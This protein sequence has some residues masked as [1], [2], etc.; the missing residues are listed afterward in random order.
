MSEILD[1]LEYN[2]FCLVLVTVC[3]CGS[4]AGFYLG[5]VPEARYPE[6]LDC[7][8]LASPHTKAKI[9]FK[10]CLFLLFGILV[11]MMIYKLRKLA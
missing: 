5:F 2:I 8:E 3:L 9:V 10:S 11:G 4:A 7:E 1:F 6:T